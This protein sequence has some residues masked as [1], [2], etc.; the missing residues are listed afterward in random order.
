MRSDVYQALEVPAGNIVELAECLR[1]VESVVSV[2]S[3][4]D[5]TSGRGYSELLGR[6][7]ALEARFTETKK[8]L[9]ADAKARDLVGRSMNGVKHDMEILQSQIMA[10]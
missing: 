3:D 7:S 10:Q 4:T 5:R 2:S 9:E 8:V 1:R 6:L